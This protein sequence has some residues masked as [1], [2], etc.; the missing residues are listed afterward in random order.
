MLMSPES[1]IEFECAGK[2]YGELLRIRDELLEEVRAFESGNIP[3]KE[4]NRLPSSEAVYELDLEILSLL[5]RRIAEAYG[6]ET[7]RSA[8]G[9]EEEEDEE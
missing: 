9:C 1:Y 3:E 2:P 4:R 8:W 6:R 5:F 7:E